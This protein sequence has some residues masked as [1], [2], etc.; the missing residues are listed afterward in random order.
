MIGQRLAPWPLVGDLDVS[1]RTAR[2][3]ASD[4]AI[5]IFQTEGELIGIEALGAAAELRPLKLFDDRL[6]ALDLAVTVLDDGRHVAQKTVQQGHVG[7][8]IV[9]IEPHSASRC[10]RSAWPAAPARASPRR[11]VRTCAA[12]R[13]R[14]DRCAW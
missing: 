12:T 14:P 7:R 13:S 9:E 10:L 8:Q 1:L 3:G 4:V 2:F 5:E 11:R 6:K